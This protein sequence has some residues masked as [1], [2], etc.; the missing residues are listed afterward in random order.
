MRCKPSLLT[1]FVHKFRI[2][3]PETFFFRSFVVPLTQGC[4][5]PS[6]FEISVELYKS[7]LLKV[8]YGFQFSVLQK[9]EAFLANFGLWM[10]VLGMC[11][12]SLYGAG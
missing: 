9:K 2:V 1:G 3:E 10:C 7:I 6:F 11:S 4:I 12:V 8:Y 5:I